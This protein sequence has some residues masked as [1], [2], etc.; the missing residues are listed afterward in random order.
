M[1]VYIDTLAAMAEKNGHPHE[2]ALSDFL[3]FLIEFFDVSNFESSETYTEKIQSTYKNQPEYFRLMLLWMNEV[4]RSMDCGK[5]LDL[6]GKLYEEMYLMKAKA[7]RTGQFFTPP[8]VSDLMSQISTSGTEKKGGRVNDCAAGSGRLLLSHYMNVTKEDHKAG[9]AYYYEAA[10]LDPM[11]CKMC[12]LNMM[13]H[14][15]NGRVVCQN[16]LS[17]S[18][19]TVIYHINEVRYPFPTE[20]YSIRCEYPAQEK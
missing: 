14:G 9:R 15:M 19:P 10:D 13:I 8:S 5:W 20:H 6:F 4:A 11:A 3:D 16:T 12:A 2:L 17:L 7:S 18:T 1:K